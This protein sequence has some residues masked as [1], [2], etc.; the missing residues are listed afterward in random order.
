MAT[1]A[2]K[3]DPPPGVNDERPARVRQQEVVADISRQVVETADL[4][5]LLDDAVAA[6]AETLGTD[7]CGA[8]ELG[9]GDELRLRRGVGWPDALDDVTV[10][11]VDD[12]Q[13]GLTLTADRWCSSRTSARRSA[14]PARS[15]SPATASPAA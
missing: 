13:L 15:Y 10:S 2:E 14:S 7:Y 12:S 5:S 8:F 3:M 11:A 1:S 6:V 4:D 9:D